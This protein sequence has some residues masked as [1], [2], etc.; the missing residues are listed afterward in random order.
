[1]T[2]ERELTAP[3]P[4]VRQVRPAPKGGLIGPAEIVGLSLSALL[5][6][7]AVV[8]YFYLV[9]P[10]R[11]RLRNLQSDRAATESSIKTMTALVGTNND[12]TQ[13][14]AELVNSIAAFEGSALSSRTA[15]RSQ[16]Y[17]QLNQLIRANNLRNTAGPSY[18]AM[19]PLDPNAPASSRTKSGNARF[20]SFYPG[21]GVN[22]TVE[23]SYAAIRR[24][25]HDVEALRQF[26]IVNA[27]ELEDVTVN[28]SGTSPGPVGDPRM[29]NPRA[30]VPAP[31]AT[32][33]GTSAVSLRL[34]LSVYFRRQ[35]S[36][37]NPL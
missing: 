12:T 19:E 1:M 10:S 3:A 15:G 16:L 6:L 37:A 26:L 7:A 23:G 8:T 34:D 5:L 13:R 11:S 31:S 18:T 25:V 2:G 9:M 22:V 30:P 27:V 20:Q 33:T 21:I 28:D 14:V 35:D 29:L 4:A 36:P 17:E 32:R 24:F